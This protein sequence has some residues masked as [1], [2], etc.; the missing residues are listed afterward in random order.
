L[1]RQPRPDAIGGLLWLGSPLPRSSRPCC[2][3]PG[4]P[5]PDRSGQTGA[6]TAAVGYG[7]FIISPLTI[8]L[9]A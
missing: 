5:P 3:W 1:P 2:R 8:G 4:R 6:T 9:L 7:A